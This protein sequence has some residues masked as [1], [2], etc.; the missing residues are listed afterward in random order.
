VW[1]ANPDS[2][3]QQV[4]ARGRR[5]QR[6]P[7]TATT[8]DDVAYGGGAVWALDRPD[9]TLWR[10]DPGPKPVSRTIPVGVGASSVAYGAGSVWVA[11]GFDGT[12][13]R[14]DPTTNRVVKRITVGGVPRAIATG[15][16][17]VWVTV[18]GPGAL[19]EAA[20][21]PVLYEGKGKPDYLI[22][23]DFPLE[24]RTL[25]YEP[26]PQ[27]LSVQAI[28]LVLR[29]HRFRAGPYKIGYQSCDDSLAQT[30]SWDA[31][32]CAANTRSF[33]D[34][35]AVLGMIGPFNSG[36]AQVEIPIANRASLPMI[37]PSNNRTGLT[38][39]GPGAEQG[40]PGKYYPT[41]LRTYFRV[42]QTYSHEAAADARLAKQLGARR[43]FVLQFGYAYGL[44]T[45]TVFARAARALGLS[46]VGRDDWGENPATYPRLASRVARARPDA[47]FLGAFL[48][49]RNGELVK[50]LRARLGPRVALIAPSG[51]APPSLVLDAVGNAAIGMY[52]SVNEAPTSALTPKARRF[53]RE[54]RRQF[55]GTEPGFPSY[56]SYTA[57]A[58]E[59][60][61]A[62][63]SRS[64]GT[65]ES[66]V[67]KLH[68]LRIVNGLLG[69]FRFDANGD[70][71]VNYT[72]IFRVMSKTPPGSPLPGSV[73]DRVLSV[74]PGLV[75]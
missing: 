72:T 43:V 61:L 59:A 12:V 20:C 36:C 3:V 31:Y 30:G 50:E 73:I 55:P 64:D 66:V 14:V 15:K 13:L 47:V 21:G 58:T 4:T 28:E 32:K 49:A 48:W 5:G 70:A 23:S 7:V 41:G 10:I 60:L 52:I 25:P 8:L 68:A 46:V 56:V 62:A 54:F 9:G 69:T 45:A 11:N 24:F 38:R 74:P 22:T 19:R 29:Q 37:S 16:G 1:L 65:R 67:R 44:E 17:A 18:G 34:D 63:I 27:S 75:R 35:P 39:S 26:Q 2:D 71:T 57:E 42:A 53:L 33:A 6:V 40:E 51:F